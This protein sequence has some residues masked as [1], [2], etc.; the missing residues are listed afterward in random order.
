MHVQLPPHFHASMRRRSPS[1]PLSRGYTP[2]DMDPHWARPMYR[3]ERPL[4]NSYRPS[5]WRP[6]LSPTHYRPPSPVYSPPYDHLPPDADSWDWNP[7]WPPYR[8]PERR[9]RSPSP[10]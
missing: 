6:D 1:P 9:P 5:N 7:S 2:Y 3:E 8:S 4:N 10:T